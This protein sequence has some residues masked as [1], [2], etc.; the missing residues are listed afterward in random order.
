MGPRH[1]LLTH[2]F[3][4]SHA[5]YARLGKRHQAPWTL[6]TA[7]LLAFPEGSLGHAVGRHLHA[8][9][10]ELLP[11]LEDHDVFHVFTGIG[12]SVVDEV[13]LQWHLA[14][15]GK[16]SAYCVG[17]AFLGTIVFPE[18]WRRFRAEWHRGAA[19]APYWRA[20]SG[21]RALAL[22]ACPLAELRVRLGGS[23]SPLGVRS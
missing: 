11:R 4:L 17:T 18:Q 8:G 13:A 21:R 2:L 16:R 22:L 10:F 5:A 15:N 23:T 1:R 14:G 9:G 6:G 12:A 19:C 7:E 3:G 20:L